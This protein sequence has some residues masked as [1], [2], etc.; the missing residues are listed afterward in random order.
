ME[1]LTATLTEQWERLHPVR[2][3]AF[4]HR[5]LVDIHPFAD[6]NG[7]TARG[8]F[9]GEKQMNSNCV[10]DIFAKIP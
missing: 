3:A 5:K 9:G 1:S 8:R 6:G 4:A 2:L 10:Y 7:R